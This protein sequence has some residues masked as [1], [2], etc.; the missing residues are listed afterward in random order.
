MLK[1]TK[2]R[3]LL[4]SITLGLCSTFAIAS[5][6]DL[7]LSGETKKEITSQLTDNGYEVRKIKTEDG[8]YEAYAIKDGIKYEVYMDKS[9]EIVRVKED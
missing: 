8:F 2:P 5:D 6:S 9:L 4:I 3:L 7:C 1:F